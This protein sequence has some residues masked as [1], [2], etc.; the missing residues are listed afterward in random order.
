MQHSSKV[1]VARASD[2]NDDGFKNTDKEMAAKKLG[3]IRV[4]LQLL[5]RKDGI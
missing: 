1:S 3:I 5:L 2:V 4:I